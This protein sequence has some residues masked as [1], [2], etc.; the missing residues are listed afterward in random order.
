MSVERGVIR[1]RKRANQVRD[2]SGLRVGNITPTDLD[3][4][5]EYKRRGYVLL[6]TKYQ[7]A[8]LPKGQELAFERMVDDL[9]IVKPAI[10]IVSTHD[11]DDDIDMANTV[12]TRYRFRGKWHTPDDE[13]TMGQLVQ[14]FL[15]WLEFEYNAQ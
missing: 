8:P 2:Y 13:I 6:E 1:N 5:I 14:R 4:L 11:T 7:G 10:V 15:H 12:V 9:Q 3:G